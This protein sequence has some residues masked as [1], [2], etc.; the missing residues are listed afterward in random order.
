MVHEQGAN[1]KVNGR[2]DR[3]LIKKN[4][5]RD[6][7]HCTWKIEH[8]FQPIQIGVTSGIRRSTC[9]AVAWNQRRTS[10]QTGTHIWQGVTHQCHTRI[11]YNII[12]Y[13]IIWTW[14]ANLRTWVF[15]S[16]WALVA[17]GPGPQIEELAKPRILGQARFRSASSNTQLCPDLIWKQ[18]NTSKLSRDHVSI[19]SVQDASQWL[20]EE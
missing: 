20:S 18:C 5:Y 14:I 2:C 7:D 4:I 10:S 13:I 19:Y 11:L 12:N 8:A 6:D 16:V 9:F 1:F 3:G 17:L 15:N